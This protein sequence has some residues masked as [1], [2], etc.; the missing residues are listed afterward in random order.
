MRKWMMFLCTLAL[1][2]CTGGSGIKSDSK[3][4]F[5][6]MLERAESYTYPSDTINL[7]TARQM[8]LALLEHDSVKTDVNK[9]MSVLRLLTD[10]A[11][12]SLDYEEQAK[13]AAQLVT[14]CREN[15]QET[16][17]LRTESEMG[18]VLTHLGQQKEGF[19]ILD[20]VIGQLEPQRHFAELD[21][22]IIA[23]KR[24]LTALSM[25]P[26][27]TLPGDSITVE[28]RQTDI[29][30]LADRYMHKL[31]DYQQHPDKYADGSDR[32]PPQ[33][34]V[35]GYC[36]FYRSQGYAILAQAYATLSEA[37]KTKNK[38]YQSSQQKAREYLARF[39]QTPFGQTLNG[40]TAISE[41]QRLLGQYDQMLAT[42]NEIDHVENSDT[43]NPNYV[44]QLRGRAVAAEAKGNHDASQ[45]YWMRHSI[46]NEAVNNQLQAS[47]AHDYAARYHAQ[48]QQREIELQREGR[49][50]AIALSITVLFFLVAFIIIALILYRRNKIIRQK[51]RSLVRQMSETMDYK[52][53]YL[54]LRRAEQQFDSST[55]ADPNTMDSQAL[56][57]YLS[58]VII[59]EQLFLNPDFD[60]QTAI[61]R[62]HLSKES[63]GAA[64]SQGSTYHSLA[65][66]VTT[67]RLEYATNLLLSQPALPIAQVASASGFSSTNH[68]GRAFK[69]AYGLSATEYR[70]AN[71]G[72][73]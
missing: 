63:V 65:T 31:D 15:H 41:T 59:D 26:S 71:K 29:I 20:K 18:I 5:S 6:T 19:A 1:L 4:D 47:Q 13:W 17:A 56:F 58:Q 36:D 22:C 3:S 38:A 53:K 39:E 51:N 64:F 12:M 40:R 68:F 10:V 21:A 44:R 50:T 33:D 49:K 16:E 61:D 14:L 34:E 57:R 30:V 35:A 52:E 73:E 43:L 55:T 42:Y 32:E 9:Q 72:K 8:G 27:I 25:L 62:F 7:D 48:E 67:C 37:L 11:R 45:H 69:N 2:S 70:T 28:Q 60:R 23:M 46:L 54:A 66:F 24:K